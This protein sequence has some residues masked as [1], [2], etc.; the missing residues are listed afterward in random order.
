MAQYENLVANG[1]EVIGYTVANQYSSDNI[2]IEGRYQADDVL[3][4]TRK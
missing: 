4:L 1:Y 2:T 3:T